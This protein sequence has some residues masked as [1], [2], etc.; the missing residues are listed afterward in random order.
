MFFAGGGARRPGFAGAFV[1]SLVF[2]AA[3]AYTRMTNSELAARRGARN[4]IE[5]QLYTDVLA[6]FLGVDPMELRSR[7]VEERAKCRDLRLCS[8]RIFAW[9]YSKA[10]PF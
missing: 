1:E 9:A 2:D 4:E 7:L 3:F 6:R 5:W 8:D 10:R